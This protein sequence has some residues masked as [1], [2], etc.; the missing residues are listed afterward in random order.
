MREHAG[1]LSLLA[2]GAGSGFIGFRGSSFG[3]LCGARFVFFRRCRLLRLFRLL[4]CAF[5]ALC[6]FRVFHRF[7]GLHHPY[8]IAQGMA[9]FRRHH[10]EEG[11][12]CGRGVV[13][14]GPCLVHQCGRVG[15]ASGDRLISIGAAFCFAA[16]P[17]LLMEVV[18]YGHDRGVGD[19]PFLLQI[20][21]DFSN[22]DRAV[23]LPDPRH[24]RVFQITQWS[25][26]TRTIV[27]DVQNVR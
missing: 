9:L 23:P 24:D 11:D 5:R 17:A 13:T 26:H 20:F 10:A 3:G 14:G 2:V 8:G 19:R 12:K 18:Q 15:G 7:V 6:A 22:G 25:R 16:H 4:L 1:T 21:Q 27:G